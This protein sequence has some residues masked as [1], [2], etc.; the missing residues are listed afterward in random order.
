MIKRELRE[1]ATVVNEN[2]RAEI[3]NTNCTASE[4]A[5]AGQP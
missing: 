1:G 4:M 3:C 5:G 2:N